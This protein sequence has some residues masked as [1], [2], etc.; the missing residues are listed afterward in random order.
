MSLTPIDLIAQAFLLGLI[1]L[2]ISNRRLLLDMTDGNV[3]RLE[4]DESRYLA[5]FDTL[6]RN[7]GYQ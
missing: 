3:E 1:L 4:A 7:E 2:A 6:K 5:R